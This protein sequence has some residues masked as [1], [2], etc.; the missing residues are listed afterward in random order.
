M[1][2]VPLKHWQPSTKLHVK[3]RIM[4]MCCP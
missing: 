3:T 1:N 4:Y 2:Q